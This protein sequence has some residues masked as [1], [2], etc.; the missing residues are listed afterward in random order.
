[1]SLI[2][3]DTKNQ[4]K[5]KIRRELILQIDKNLNKTLPILRKEVQSL[6]REYI[7]KQPH[8][9]SLLGAGG[10]DSLRAHFGIPADE[11]HQRIDTIVEATVK[12]IQTTGRIKGEG[13]NLLG[14]I[15][16]FGVDNSYASLFALP[17]ATIV[18]EKGTP[19]PWL[20]WL[21]TFGDRGFIKG[22]NVEGIYGR[23]RSGLAIM[24]KQ[25]DIWGVPSEFASRGD[26]NWLT[27]AVQEMLSSG[28]F[29]RRINKIL[30]NAL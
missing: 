13:G 28:N 30:R 23:G 6:L 15:R 18:T 11:R 12:S 1:M 20:E 9:E 7:Q 22:Y 24:I 19:L 26:S 3:K 2:L 27:D 10:T 25:Q 4:I 16:I 21:L 5:N 14:R 17:E 29:V 8:Y